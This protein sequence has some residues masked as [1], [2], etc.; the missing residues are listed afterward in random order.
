[1]NNERKGLR[2]C[3]FPVYE[4][5]EQKSFPQEDKIKTIQ[6]RG[7]FHKFIYTECGLIAI[8]ETE[9]GT[10]EAPKAQNIKFLDV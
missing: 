9:E 4:V 6:T 7:Y 5:I 3:T 10:I 2:P 1:M 8:V